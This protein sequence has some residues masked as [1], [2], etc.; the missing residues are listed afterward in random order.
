M[1]WVSASQHAS[2]L[3]TSKNFPLPASEAGW[4]SSTSCSSQVDKLWR[5]GLGQ[6]LKTCMVVGDGWLDS[7]PFQL[8]YSLFS[9][10]SS[11]NLV[12]FSFVFHCFILTKLPSARVLIRRNRLHDAERVMRKIYSHATNE[13]LTLKVI[14]PSP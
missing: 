12:S 8:D 5:M 9:C 7:A 11:Q 1:V 3:Y 6:H 2:H 4:W 10:S 14:N 13:Q